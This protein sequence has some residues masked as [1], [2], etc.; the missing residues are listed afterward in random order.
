M[1]EEEIKNKARELLQNT[2]IALW[3]GD[4]EIFDV[5][6][7][8]VN[9]DIEADEL[10]ILSKTVKNFEIYLLSKRKVL[11]QNEDINYLKNIAKLLRE[12]KVRIHDEYPFASPIFEVSI[13]ENDKNRKFEFITREGAEKYIDANSTTLKHLP[14]KEE[15]EGEERRKITLFEI[16][17]NTNLEVEKILEI[18]KRVF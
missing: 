5:L 17:G 12:Q 10:D 7:D 3:K 4:T 9:R 8:I 11:V 6:E 2:K 13:D 15:G 16:E 1:R 18:I 14:K